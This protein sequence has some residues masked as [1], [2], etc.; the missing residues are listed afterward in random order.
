MRKLTKAKAIAILL[1]DTMKIGVRKPTEYFMLVLEINQHEL[2]TPIKY[3]CKMELL[4][5]YDGSSSGGIER[6]KD[7]SF[8]SICSNMGIEF[9]DNDSLISQCEEVVDASR[10]LYACDV[11]DELVPYLNK[12]SVCM[13]C[14]ALTMPEP[15]KRMA[16]CGHLSANR[17][18]NCEACEPK[19]QDD[20]MEY[21]IESFQSTSHSD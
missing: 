20:E 16:R 7:E 10:Q 18:F 1:Y 14:A 8:E 4:K 3:L 15:P 2:Y 13:G 21:T 9:K 6:I 5:T 17:Y 11:C 12:S 19:L